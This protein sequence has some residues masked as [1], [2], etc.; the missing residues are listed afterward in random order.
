MPVWAM[1][2]PFGLERTVT[3]GILSGIHRAAKA[4]NLF[5]DFMQSDAAVNPGNSGGPLVNARGQL[6]GVNTAIVGD[7]YRGVSFSP[8]PVTSRSRFT[9]D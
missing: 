4:G 5:Q 9:Y 8:F 7:T 6:V 2:S 3:S 1:G